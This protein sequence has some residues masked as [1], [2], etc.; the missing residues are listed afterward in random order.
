MILWKSLGLSHNEDKYN[1]TG[2]YT[3]VVGNREKLSLF[4]K[5]NFTQ[6][7]TAMKDVST[8]D[9]GICAEGF[10]RPGQVKPLK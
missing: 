10:T 8:H 6:T 4:R 5:R 3:E 2:M 1:E 7:N 9:K